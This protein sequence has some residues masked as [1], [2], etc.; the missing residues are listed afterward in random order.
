MNPIE[1]DDCIIYDREKPLICDHCRRLL[2]DSPREI[3][4]DGTRMWM[5]RKCEEPYFQKSCQP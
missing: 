2:D 5:H 3:W 4:V 1:L